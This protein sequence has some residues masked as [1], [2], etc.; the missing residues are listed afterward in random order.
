VHDPFETLLRTN[1]GGGTDGTAAMTLVQ[2]MIAEPRNT[3]VV[4]ISDFY[5]SRVEEL[6]A[7]M[8]AIHRSGAKFIPVGS[9]NSSGS[10]S[11]SPWFKERFKDQGTPVISGH[12]RKLVRELKTFLA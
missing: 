3:V 12:I 1:L 6:F 10:G 9:V 4:W 7:S 5:E 8:A 2:P 11:V